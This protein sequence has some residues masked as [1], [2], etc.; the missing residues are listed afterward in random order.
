ML[1]ELSQKGTEM[2]HHFIV[3]FQNDHQKLVSTGTSLAVQYLRLRASN[4]GGE[5]SIPSQGTNIPLARLNG[6]K[7]K[8]KVN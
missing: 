6:K 3:D 8:K 7:K 5:G 1:S 4:A 2:T